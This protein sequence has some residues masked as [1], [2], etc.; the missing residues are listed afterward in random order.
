MAWLGH[1]LLADD[2][3]GGTAAAGM[4]RQA[5]HAFQLAFSHPV[6]GQ[7]LSFRADLPGDFRA[8]MDELGLRYNFT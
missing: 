1:P 6:T 8:A 5:L 7:A 2:T 3:Y 4:D